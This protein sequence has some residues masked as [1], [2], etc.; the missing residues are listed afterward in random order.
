LNRDAWVQVDLGAIV[1]NAHIL[2]DLAPHSEV[3]PVVKAEAYGHGAAAVS[4]ALEAA[5]YGLFCVATLDE[6]LGLRSGGL[7]ARILL[8]Y[9]PAQRGWPAAAAAGLEIAVTSREGLERA[10]ASGGEADLPR[11]HLKIDT[12]MSRQGLLPDDVA[13]AARNASKLQPITAGIWTHLRDGADPASAG[14]QLARFDEAVGELATAGLT[15]PRHA[16]ASAAMMSGQGVGYEMVRPGLALFGLTPDEAL[17][18]GVGLPAGI[19]PALSI[20]ARP[21]RLARLPAGT[22]VGYGGTFVTE[23]PT[24]LATLPLGYADGIFRSLGNEGWSVLV[25]GVRTPIVGRVSM[26]GIT[27]DVTDVEGVQRDDLFTIIGSQ[28]GDALTGNAMAAA[29]GTIPQEIL[30]RFA[31]RLPYEYA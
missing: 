11:V 9:E 8:L 27:V 12:G 31:A 20:H 29:A 13:L 6:G 28:G 16:A 3:A 21:V 19:R 17:A 7:R 1:G 25:R 14:P 26:D 24:L 30:V 5:G 2:A 4:L 18:R 15:A 10:I 23:R 22:P